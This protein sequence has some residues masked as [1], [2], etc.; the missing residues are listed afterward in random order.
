M[1]AIWK[2]P[3]QITGIQVISAPKDAKPV[4][5]GLDPQGT[6]CIWALGTPEEEK[7]DITILMFGTGHPIHP[8]I[9]EKEHIG[10]IVQGAFV[11]HV[12]V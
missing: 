4:H 5:V 12:F 10:T 3:I 8:T 2:Y 7:D 9:T 11:W 6:P 1:K